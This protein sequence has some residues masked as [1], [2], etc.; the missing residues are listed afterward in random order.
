GVN[1]GRAGMAKS[2][3]GCLGFDSDLDR[4]AVNLRMASAS[5]SES[6]CSAPGSP[7]AILAA[8]TLPEESSNR[9]PPAGHL[10]AG[11]NH[12]SEMCPLPSE[13]ANMA[14]GFSWAGQGVAASN[15][16]ARAKAQFRKDPLRGPKGPL[17][18]H[19]PKR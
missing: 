18:H 5:S 10:D 7:M 8:M 3:G 4:T 19:C 2:C 11:G 9:Q 1:A 15:N 14:P 13:A 16:A 6:F 17:F 12:R